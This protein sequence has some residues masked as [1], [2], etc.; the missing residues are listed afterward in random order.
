MVAMDAQENNWA[1]IALRSAA[2]LGGGQAFFGLFSDLLERW[3]PAGDGIGHLVGLPLAS[4]VFVAA[5]APVLRPGRRAVVGWLAATVTNV[6]RHARAANCEITIRAAGAMLTVSVND[7]GCG[8]PADALPGVGLASMRERAEELGG[9]LAAESRS[10]GGTSVV[11][12]LPFP[13]G[14]S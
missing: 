3:G 5:M 13:G 1:G 7:D 11:A 10:G 12:T 8:L 2:G 9:R 6:R 4:A 14:R